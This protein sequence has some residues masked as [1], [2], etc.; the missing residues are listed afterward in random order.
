M[1]NLVRNIFSVRNLANASSKI[2]LKNITTT[3]S[4]ADDQIIDGYSIKNYVE[5]LFHRKFCWK[6]DFQQAFYLRNFSFIMPSK[7]IIFDGIY[8]FFDEKFPHVV[9]RSDKDY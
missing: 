3:S 9:S 2:P 8:N 1:K 6:C 7:I 5:K 4:G